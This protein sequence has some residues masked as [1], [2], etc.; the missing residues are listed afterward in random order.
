MKVLQVLLTL[1]AGGAEGFVTNLSVSLAEVGVEV[2]V[3]LVA[4]LR[5][6]RG[7][8]LY[9]RLLEAGIEVI[10]GSERKRGA[11][12]GNLTYIA[13]LPLSIQRWRPDIVQVNHRIIDL[14]CA[15]AQILTLGSG[16]SFVRRLANTKQTGGYRCLTVARMVDRMYRRTIA[17]SPSTADAYRDFMRDSQRSEIVTVPNGGL[18]LDSVPD[19]G[20]KLRARRDL[21][22]PEQAFVVTHIGRM[23]GGDHPNSSLASGQKAQ[24]VLIKAFA[25]AFENDSDCRFVILGDG[26]LRPEAEALAQSLGIGKHVHFVG[27]QPEPWPVLKAADMFCFP[28]RHEGLPNVLPEAGSAG[29]P[30]VA[31]DIPEIRSLSPGDAWLL[32][33]VDDV[34]RFA[35]A[36]RTVRNRQSEFSRK[37]TEA[38]D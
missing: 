19:A 3:F 9:E 7:Q 24:D 25:Q 37:A 27:Q 29:L 20:E 11:S 23:F 8:V 21:G 30:V 33:P 18:L 15:V 2:K 10:G 38:A 1:S 36:M 28:S 16:A 22:I 34:A 17:C 31:S 6:E 35:A 5:G 32:E 13:R 4:G 26:P 14:P 12:L